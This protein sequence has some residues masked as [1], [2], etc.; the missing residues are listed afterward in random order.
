M[1]RKNLSRYAL[2]VLLVL[3]TLPSCQRSAEPPARSFFE[4]LIVGGAAGGKIYLEV[5]LKPSF[6]ANAKTP[7]EQ[8]QVWEA[9]FKKAILETPDYEQMLRDKGSI[10]EDIPYWGNYVIRKTDVSYIA[11]AADLQIGDILMIRTPYELGTAKVVSYQIHDGGPVVGGYLL[12]AIAEPFN[13]FKPADTRILVADRSLPE[14]RPSC[15][16]RTSKPDAKRG[17][18]ILDRMSHEA[19]NPEVHSVTE[20]I[21]LEGHFTRK[22]APQYIA[23]LRFGEYIDSK[24]R[25][26]VL[27]S[28]LKIILVLGENEYAHIKPLVIA[29]IN[30]DGLDEI[31]TELQGYEGDHFAVWYW[32]GGTG[33]DAF[34]A[35]ATTYYGL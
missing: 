34:R 17:A 23:Y 5:P 18:R 12:V 20:N 4:K 35:V 31:W 29:D 33:K 21:I 1:G 19:A 22:D 32:R 25:T 14:C 11:H 24:W 16:G 9:F 30:N 8:A 28:D 27:D 13:G 15:A 6:F 26:V 3:P 2:L 10:S 7:Q